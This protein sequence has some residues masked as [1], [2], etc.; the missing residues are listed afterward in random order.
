MEPSRCLVPALIRA[1]EKRQ[2]PNAGRF[3]LREDV[4][5]SVRTI[6]LPWLMVADGDR[7]NMTG[8]MVHYER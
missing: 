5:V 7:P 4:L 3:N 1:A 2:K 8:P 6:L